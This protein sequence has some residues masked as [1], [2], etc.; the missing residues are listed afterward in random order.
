MRGIYAIAGQHITNM[1]AK[2]ILSDLRDHGTA[3]A[4]T[5]DRCDDIGRSTACYTLKMGDFFECAALLL[6][7]KIN[8]Q[9]ANRCDFFHS[10]FSLAVQGNCSVFLFL[11]LRIKARRH[12]LFAA[13]DKQL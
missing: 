4:E 7:Y 12:G 2:R 6:R 13:I 8:E 3:S 10:H 5:A 11:A 1:F 9:F